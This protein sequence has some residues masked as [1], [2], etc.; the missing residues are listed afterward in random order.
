MSKV[1]WIRLLV[2]RFLGGMLLLAAVLKSHQLLTEPLAN[3][4]I[5][6]YRPFLVFQVEFELALGIWLLSGLFRTAGWLAATACFGAFSLV[7]LYRGLTGAESCGC[8]GSVHVNPWVT[9]LAIDLPAVAALT[10]LRPTRAFAPLWLFLRREIRPR[11]LLVE[12]LTPQ[13]RPVHLVATACVAVTVLGITAPILAL[14]P[15]PLVTATYEVLEPETWTGE[16]LP[17]LDHIDIAERLRNGV[18]L[19]LFYHYDCPDC[20]QAVPQYEQMARDLAG[21]DDF[22]QVALIEVPP[23]GHGPVAPDSPCVLGR[24]DQSKEWF[25]TTPVVVLVSQ[26]QVVSAWEGKAPGLDT[27]LAWMG[28]G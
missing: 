4:N 21:N 10:L 7:T 19:L 25:V 16:E 1:E 27:V 18:W 14:I 5:W 3:D 15:P 20:Q 6:S 2:P 28:A 11:G 8:F 23:Y 9:L 26:R 13:P 22:L 12:W 17:V 24:M